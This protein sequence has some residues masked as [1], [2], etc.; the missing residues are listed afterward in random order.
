MSYR[1]KKCGEIKGS[2]KLIRKHI[3]EVHNI[4]S[5]K[6]EIKGQPDAKRIYQSPISEAYE[7][8]G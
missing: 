7:Y 2:R 3:K 6:H 1:C 8:V 4:K 5:E